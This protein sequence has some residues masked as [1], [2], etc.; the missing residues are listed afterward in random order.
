VSKRI[1][2]TLIAAN[3]L[4]FGGVYAI[5]G[6]YLLAVFAVAGALTWFLV[7]HQENPMLTTPFFVLFMGLALWGCLQNLPVPVMLLGVSSSLAAWD[8]SRFHGRAIA[9]ARGEI[10]PALELKHL[11]KL[12]ITAVASFLVALVPLALT[13]SL[14]FVA[15]ALLMLLLRWVLRRMMMQFRAAGNDSQRE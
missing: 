13:I 9:E 12:A 14:N 7:E 15:L 5:S 1:S 2:L 8:L 3:A 6:R 10:R 11:Q 4:L